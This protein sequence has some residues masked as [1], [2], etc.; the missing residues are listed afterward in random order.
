[1]SVICHSVGEIRTKVRTWHG[2]G[3][4]VALVPTMGALH[5]GH[6]CLVEAAKKAADVVVVSIFVNPKQFGAGE[7]FGT[8]PRTLEA[9]AALCEAYG[10]EAIFAPSS[11]AMYPEGFATTLHVSGVSEG[12]CGASRP[13]HFDGVATVVAKLLMQVGTDVAL[14]GEKDFQQLQVIRR[15]VED[16]NLPVDILGVATS[17]EA[18][19]LARSSRNAYLTKE[20]REVAPILYRQLSEAAE[21]IGAGEVIMGV[22]NDV[23]ESLLQSGFSK[24]DY[25]T[26]CEE[27]SLTPLTQWHGEP[28]RIL[29]AAHLG[30][31]RLIDNVPLN[32][33]A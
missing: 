1:M 25:I 29:A 7:D 24:V 3:K 33:Q 30:N 21:R 11:A 19:G 32:P 22:L 23:Q 26:C 28:A 12:L 20:E 31:A 18:D 16:I 13:G 4:R 17:R 27:R 9:D 14:F 10:V 15:M 8:Y 5:A 6:M 2:E